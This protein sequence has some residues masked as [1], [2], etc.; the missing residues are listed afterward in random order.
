ML[1]AFYIFAALL[2]YLSYKSFRGGIDYL[3]Y[4]KQEL[5]RPPSEFMPFATVIAPCKG[6]DE[7][8]EQNLAA[9]IEQDYPA[10]EVIF[11]VDDQRDSA[12]PVIDE[13][14]SR[15]DAEPQSFDARSS[16]DP[17]L[18]RLV[19]SKLVVAP[20]AVQSS[21][22]VENLR[23]AVLHADHRSKAF[24]FVDSDA[25]PAKDWL[26][27]LVAPL[28]DES[29]G[30]ASGYRWFLS[31]K[32][33]FASELRSAWNASIASALGPNVKSN[34]CWGGSTAILRKTFE[35]I[36]MRENWKGTLS[37]D[38]AV[39]RTLNEAGLPIH[40][41]P[42]ALIPSIESC[43]MRECLEFTTRQ[44]KITRVYMAHLWLLSF[45]GSGLFTFVILSSILI[46]V[47]SKQNTELV[48]AAL[49]T[50]VIVSVFSVGKAWLRLKAV[51]KVIPSVSKQTFAQ[52]TL[53]LL[54]P[55]LFL[56]NSILALL[57]RRLKWRGITYELVSPTRTRRID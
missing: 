47:F 20:T 55:P 17:P 18:F 3:N 44:M 29:I 6:I 50:L 53:W 1:I 10:Y 26:R 19:S 57:S 11:V 22:K 25:R 37:D 2:I 15:N 51:R 14:V 33:T 54:S 38:F 48:W 43:S 28:S 49:A 12:V 46:A 36:D 21:Q 42:R 41:V 40:F 5:A 16:A 39:T 13:I 27:S 7:G 34:F 30:A 35:R 32:P 45:F 23:E 9:L 56:L 24:V 4:F 52:L 8:L 31:V